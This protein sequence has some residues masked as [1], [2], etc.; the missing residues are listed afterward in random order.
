M[1]IG[2]KMVGV[3][4]RRVDNAIKTMLGNKPKR[5][6]GTKEE[7]WIKYEVEDGKGV[8]VELHNASGKMDDIIIG[9]LDFN[10]EA[11]SMSSYYRN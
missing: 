6:V 1:D 2:D 8:L 7:S 10:Q 4:S 11:R 3:D 9:K 5:R